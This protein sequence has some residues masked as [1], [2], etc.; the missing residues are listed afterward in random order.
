[1]P[2]SGGE[3]IK[4]SAFIP[5]STAVILLVGS[6]TLFFVFTCPWL[7][8]TVS[9]YVPP[10]SAILFFFV[11]ANF[12]MATFMDAGVLP[13]A[14]EDEDKDD[15]FHAPLYKN[16]EVKGVQVRMKW[17]ASCH[18]YRPPRC[19]H[20][21]VCDHCVQD[22]DHH[23]PWVNNCIGRRNYRYFFLFLLSLTLHMVGV[24]LGGLL[25]IL[26][27]TEDLWKLHCTVT[28]VVMSVSALFFIPVLGLTGFHFYLVFRGRTTN[29]QV[30][31]KFQGGV[32]P[33]TR[34]C[35]G[36]LEYLICS[37]ISPKYTERLIKKSTVRVMP[38]FLRP[39]TDRQIPTLKVGD[40]G[41]NRHDVQNKRPSTDAVDEPDIK[42]VNSPPPLPPKPDPNLLKSQLAA[43]EERG[44]HHKPAIPLPGPNLQQIKAL[45]QSP[46][47]KAPPPSPVQQV[48][49]VPD[50]QGRS[51]SKGHSV[52]PEHI[53]ARVDK[54]LAIPP[55]PT[56]TPLQLNSL[57]LNSRSLT[58][59]HAYRHGNKPPALHPEGPTSRQLSPGV[60]PLHD[61][62]SSRCSLSYD[63]LVN[64]ADP[65]YPAQR[66]A[67]PLHYHPRFMTLGPDSSVLQRPPPHAYSPVFMGATRH[68]PQ[69]RDTSLRD[70][71]LRDLTPHALTSRDLTPHA[72][73][74]R[75]L[76]PHALTSRDLTPHALTSRDL[77]PHALTSRDLTPHALT[78]RDLTPQ[79]LIH[80][81]ASPVRYDNLS[82]TI[83][84][85]IQERR[86]ME[87]RDNVLRMQAR[88]QG[89]YS[90][91]D[92]GVY[93]IPSRRSLPTD[94]MR[95]PGSRGPTPPAYG[96]RE[97]MMSTGILGYGGTRSPLSSASS[98]SLSRAPRTSSSPPQ[99]SSSLQSKARSPSPAYLP[100]DR[101][102]SPS[103]SSSTLPRTSSSSSATAQYVHPKRPSLT[104]PGKEGKDSAPLGA[105]K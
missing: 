27:H 8:V 74:S 68:S 32:N 91:P 67:P 23:C 66:G 1:M 72:L 99:S 90:C 11:L 62:L 31:G 21:S 14:N 55:G 65:H 42:H 53:L 12:T 102:A 3:R 104:Y 20:C 56:S 25:Y 38:P 2:T 94:S 39:E 48:S 36:N 71:A 89:L 52:S 54:Q 33:F 35:C 100:P 87:E 24:F 19:S 4:A 80:M 93:D 28:L 13:M 57:T 45:P 44:P 81:E 10:C 43:K 34:G 82:K 9:I 79:A 101:H 73:T 41:L 78:S 50:Q 70:P 63:S 77:T 84:A 15:D 60:F 69:P 29:E 85:S 47:A 51:N 92:M 18:F 95:L 22:F 97:F 5:V 61:P 59:K 88:N 49:V 96:S 64:S 37:P 58:L 105:A 75:D 86:E 30:T 46:S 76:T 6:T 98:S 40:N 7:A 17:C 26:H 16:V 83:M 103:S